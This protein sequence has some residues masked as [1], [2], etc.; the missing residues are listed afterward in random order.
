MNT[1]LTPALLAREMIALASHEPLESLGF[2]PF[3][4]TTSFEFSA[5]E[6]SGRL[7]SIL[8]GRDI[9]GQ[10]LASKTTMRP[11]WTGRT[12]FESFGEWRM[13]YTVGEGGGYMMIFAHFAY[14]GHVRHPGPF[15]FWLGQHG[16]CEYV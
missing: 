12:T 15:M 8:L 10:I 11:R 6:R 14:A 16:D 4:S 9:V 7:D 13:D 5:E 3:E 2:A 1:L